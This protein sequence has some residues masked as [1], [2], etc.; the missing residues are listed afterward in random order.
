MTPF[1]LQMDAS[2]TGVDSYSMQQELP[3]GPSPN[4]CVIFPNFYT[5]KIIFVSV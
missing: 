4:T 3:R 5:F 1:H 2:V